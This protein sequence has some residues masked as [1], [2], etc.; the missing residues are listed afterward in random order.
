MKEDLALYTAWWVYRFCATPPR[1]PRGE[2]PANPSICRLSLLG[3]L[4]WG[5]LF[6]WA[7]RL[8]TEP[9]SRLGNPRLSPLESGELERARRLTSGPMIS[10]NRSSNALLLLRSHRFHQWPGGRRPPSSLYGC[11]F[12]RAGRSHRASGIIG[13]VMFIALSGVIDPANLARRFD[14]I[15][16]PDFIPG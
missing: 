14:L 3:L 7:G 15:E 5:F 8:V 13:W 6:S 11:R 9:P 4:I 10:S 2:T 12:H 16:W 1:A